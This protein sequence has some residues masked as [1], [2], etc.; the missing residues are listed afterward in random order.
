MRKKTVHKTKQAAQAAIRRA[1]EEHGPVAVG[2]AIGLHRSGKHPI[3]HAVVSAWVEGAI[4]SV[5]MRAAISAWSRG[6]IPVSAW[7]A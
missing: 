2:R 7:D 4:P 1:V 3:R 5:E 6:A